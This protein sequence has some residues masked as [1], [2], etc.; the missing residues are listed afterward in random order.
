MRSGCLGSDFLRLSGA[1]MGV[2]FGIRPLMTR[3][4]LTKQGVQCGQVWMG[5]FV[6][7]G[8]GGS[9]LNLVRRNCDRIRQ[10]QK[11]REIASSGIS[12]GILDE[13]TSGRD[14]SSLVSLIPLV[15]C[16]PNS[17]EASESEFMKNP[18]ASIIKCVA[19]RYWVVTAGLIIFETLDSVEARRNK[20]RGH[21]YGSTVQKWSEEASGRM[22]LVSSK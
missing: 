15:A 5:L 2:N 19:N 6:K 18:V 3:G 21:H 11:E 12:L 14:D 4:N 20:T 13:G 16:Q 10:T 7:T 1:Q 9:R 17:R 22:K 8:I